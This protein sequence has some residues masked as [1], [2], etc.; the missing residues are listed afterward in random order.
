M[1]RYLAYIA[2]FAA[3][4]AGC[5]TVGI[6][7]VSTLT[8]L[9]SSTAKAAR[10]ISDEEEYYVGRAVAARILSTYPLLNNTA[11][12]EYVNLVGMTVALN[13]DKPLTHGGYHFAVL[14]SREPNA[15]AAPGGS[16][17]I[18]RGLIST[19]ANEDELAAV[20]AHEVA[21]INHRDGVAAIQ[22]SRWTEVASI[23]GKEA[24]R[25]YAPGQIS[26]LVNLFE[27]SVDDVFKTIVVNG[28]GRGQERSADETALV[29]LARSGYDPRAL[30]TYLERLRTRPQASGGIT[31]THPGTAERIDTVRNA[32]PAVQPDPA[33]VQKR[34]ERFK[35]YLR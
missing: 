25:S 8:T 10:P 33:F 12:T 31:A 35:R 30:S 17:F 26:T 19:I 1:K 15:F 16:I 24:V 23:V 34:T 9:A 7:D 21:H 2:F 14:D 6:P 22:S 5:R 20:L 18:T 27:G 28:Y 32:M 11:L 29:I 3:L 13:S 4:V